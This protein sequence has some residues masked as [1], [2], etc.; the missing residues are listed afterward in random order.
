MVAAQGCFLAHYLDNLF[1][2]WMLAEAVVYS[3]LRLAAGLHSH[4]CCRNA[5]RQP[6]NS[7][8]ILSREAAELVQRVYLERER[9]QAEALLAAN[10]R[11]MDFVLVD[12]HYPVEVLLAYIPDSTSLPSS[13]RSDRSHTLF[14]PPLFSHHHT[15]SEY[16]LFLL[17]N[18]CRL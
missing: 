7:I 8:V 11:E 9:H 13:R 16:L 5:M 3:A 1:P 12:S 14:R 4:R 15:P 18:P 10:L 2:A 17:R 6:S